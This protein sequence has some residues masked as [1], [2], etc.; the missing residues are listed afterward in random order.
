MLVTCENWQKL[1]KLYVVQEVLGL[2][3]HNDPR[4]I[5][6]MHSGIELLFDAG[7]LYFSQLDTVDGYEVTCFDC[8]ILSLDHLPQAS[9][10]QTE[11]KS[12]DL[13]ALREI[14]SQHVLLKAIRAKI[15]MKHVL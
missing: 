5:I 15:A 12:P 13:T 2:S 14:S 1:L 9:A 7:L 6:L 11:D 8:F 3:A 4:N 10:E